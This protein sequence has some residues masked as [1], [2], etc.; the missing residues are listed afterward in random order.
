MSHNSINMMDENSNTDELTV[1][2]LH[3]LLAVDRRRIVL[4]ILTE[5][6]A[7]VELKELAVEVAEREDQL[8]T[9]D[10]DDLERVAIE[11]YHNHLPRLDDAGL[12]DY[13]PDGHTVDPT[14]LR[15][16]QLEDY[17]TVTP[18]RE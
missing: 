16:Y 10:E 17:L 9:A 3:S 18:E 8:D 5:V 6:T 4:N 14:K 1:S 2:D 12:V 13:D 11:L 7:T 15:D